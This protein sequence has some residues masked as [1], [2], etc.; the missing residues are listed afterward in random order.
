MEKLIIQKL[1]L[2]NEC[3]NMIAW[4]LREP[5]PTAR[6]IKGLT[7]ERHTYGFKPL[8]ISGEQQG[9]NRRDAVFCLYYDSTTGEKLPDDALWIPISR[10]TDLERFVEQAEE[11][12][13]RRIS[14]EEVD[15]I[16]QGTWRSM[17]DED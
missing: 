5:T 14:P 2:P 3:C 8:I 17:Y 13:G 12:E 9:R 16:R 4:F 6:L 15:V 10:E 7:F 11:I 1:K